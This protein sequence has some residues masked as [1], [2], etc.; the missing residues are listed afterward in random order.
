MLSKKR[1]SA[2]AIAMILTLSIVASAM[3]PNALAQF[4]ALPQPGN[5]QHIYAFVNVGPNPVGVGQV[6]TINFFMAA[7]LVTSAAGGGAG[8]VPQNWTVVMTK[9]NGDKVVLGPFKGDT[10]GGSYTTFTPDQVGNYTFKAIFAQQLLI[11]GVTALAAESPVVTLVVQEEPV[12]LGHYQITPLP[13]SWWQTPVTAENVQEWYKI[14]GPWLGYG[15]VVFAQTGGYNAT[16]N[17]NPKTESVM[18]GHILWTKIWAGGG[19]N[20]L[21]GDE[22]SGHYWSTSQYWPKFAPVIINGIMYSDWKAESNSYQNG[23]I[24]VDLYTGQTLWRINTTTALRCGMVTQWYT[25]NMYGSVGPYIWTTGT[26]P[27]ADTGGTRPANVG[28]QWNMYSGLT[29]QYVLSIVNGTNPTLTTDENGHIIG[30]YINSTAG[31]MRTFGNAPGFGNPPVT[32]YVTIA[33]DRPVLVCWNLSQALGSNWGW[34]PS[35]N[36]VI[37]FE[38]GIMWAKPLPNATDKGEPINNPLIGVTNPVMAINGITNNA[39]VMTAG[40]TFGQGTGGQQVGWLLCGAMDASTG[41]VL[42]AHNFT[43]TETDTL[44]PDSRTNVWIQDGKLILVN[45]AYSDAFAIDARTGKKAW[46]TDL[47]KSDGSLPHGYNAFG[48]ARLNGP[49]SR[50]AILGFG[51]DIWC[52]NATT[53]TQLWY[54]STNEILGNPGLETPYGVWPIWSFNSHAASKDFAYVAIGHEYNPPLFHG[55]QLLALNWTDGSLGWKILDTSVESTSIAYGVLLS[56]NC[57][58]NMIYAFG[59][60]PSKMTLDAPHVGVTTATPITITGTIMDVSPG[61]RYLAQPEVTMTKQNE[62]ALRFPNGVP[63][64]S[65]ESQ[66]HWMEYVYQQQPLPTNTTGVE[67]TIDVIDSNNNYRTIGTTTSDT[68][69]SFSFTWTPDIPGDFTVIATFAGSNS[70]YGSCAEA[71]FTATEAATPAPVITPQPGLA[72]AG[73]VMMYSVIVAIAIIIAIAIVGLLIL[74][75]KP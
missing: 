58:D 57:Y 73:D 47:R 28:T 72:T 27:A 32:G 14:A 13:T 50:I 22:Q 49:E 59:K 66:S 10:T 16:G 65:D 64:V 39:V 25:P 67:I 55:A 75:K 54:T 43:S 23:I 4:A 2:I 70:Y 12:Q 17:Y 6:V 30:Y 38:R 37:P 24:A 19:V 40:F 20:G 52:L 63:C 29:G 74:R 1:A 62:V 11:N 41:D 8:D 31:T 56:R 26:L 35:L 21:S 5:V 3:L 71:H 68:T 46:N 33:P 15:S 36:T 60:G 48:L 7:P 34:G 51:G 44:A 42:W 61:T 9:P 69:G 18:S 53:G 45:M